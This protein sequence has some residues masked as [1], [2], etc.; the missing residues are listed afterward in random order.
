MPRQPPPRGGRRP[1][2]DRDSTVPPDRTTKIEAH[3]SPAELANLHSVARQKHMSLSD[4]VRWAL[5][6]QLGRLA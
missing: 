6:Q 4:M 2:D 1:P 5:E 3:V